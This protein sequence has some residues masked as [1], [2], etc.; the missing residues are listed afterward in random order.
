MP[1]AGVILALVWAFFASGCHSRRWRAPASR[2]DAAAPAARHWNGPARPPTPTASLRIPNGEQTRCTTDAECGPGGECFT[3]GLDALYSGMFRDCGDG[4]VWRA[5]HGL[6]TCIH[7]D[8]T[9]DEDCPR[10]ER[11]AE[12]QMLPFPQRVCVPAGCQSDMDCR[13]P[14]LGV[15]TRYVGGVHCEHGGW[16]CAWPNDECAPGVPERRCQAPR[17]QL[18]YCVPRGGRFRCVVAAPESP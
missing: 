4:Q 7:P 10:D 8:C 6:H 3:E 1:R 13:H 5:R 9:R 12:R 15:C 16:A 17:G 2:R 11:C 14:R 18:A